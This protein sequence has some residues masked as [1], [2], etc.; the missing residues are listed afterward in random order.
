M[1]Y[2]TTD[3][4][5]SVNTPEQALARVRHIADSAADLSTRLSAL[6]DENDAYELEQLERIAVEWFVV[7]DVERLRS[8]I[9]TGEKYLARVKKEYREFLKPRVVTRR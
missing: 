7:T 9:K 6:L 5:G 4:P 1:S 8:I 2:E 3:Q